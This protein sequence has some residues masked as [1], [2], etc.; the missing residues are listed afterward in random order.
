MCVYRY[1]ID[2]SRLGLPVL[3][4]LLHTNAITVP[5]PK[6]LNVRLSCF[7]TLCITA[8]SYWQQFPAARVLLPHAE[9]RHLSTSINGRHRYRLDQSTPPPAAIV[10][11]SPTQCRRPRTPPRKLP[12]S[13]HESS[14]ESSHAPLALYPPRASH[15]AFYHH[16][17]KCGP[18][19]LQAVNR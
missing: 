3:K 12:R 9:L 17:V 14:H 7:V 8:L 18:V 16:P 19:N 4:I 11:R 13:S 15:L 2:Q 5:V 6:S 10:R 1:S